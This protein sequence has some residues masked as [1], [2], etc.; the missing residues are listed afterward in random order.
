MTTARSSPRCS[1]RVTAPSPM[2]RPGCSGAAVRRV[3]SWRI[4]AAD[5]GP[6]SPLAT[7]NGELRVSL[8]CVFEGV[9]R[10]AARASVR[11]KSTRLEAEPPSSSTV[12][13]KR[14]LPLPPIPRVAR[15]GRRAPKTARSQ[16]GR[17]PA[18]TLT[19]A[20]PGK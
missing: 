15:R 12:T 16:D 11:I 4:T 14:F 5:A 10:L 20:R 17:H 3:T 9:A 8:R 18:I 19:L 6:V 7:S 2:T 1:L 13:A